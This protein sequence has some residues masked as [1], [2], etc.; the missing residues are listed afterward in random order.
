MLGIATP[1]PWK[2]LDAFMAAGIYLSDLGAD[3]TSYTAQ[4]NAAC[5]YYSGGSCKTSNGST[6]YGNSVMALADRI[7]RDQ[8][9]LLAGI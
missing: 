8:I 6:S 1:N 3:S 9:N 2:P 7:Q 5:R 4:R